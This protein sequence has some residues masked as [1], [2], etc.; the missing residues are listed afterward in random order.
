MPP[1]HV[2]TRTSAPGHLPPGLVTI[3][4]N[5]PE[6]SRKDSQMSNV[7]G[8]HVANWA[9]FDSRWRCKIWLWTL[10]GALIANFELL[11]ESLETAL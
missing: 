4:D 6:S 1:G 8:R 7:F 10:F 11:F 5:P 9:A 3:P 2:P